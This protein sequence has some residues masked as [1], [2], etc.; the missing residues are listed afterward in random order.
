MFDKLSDI[1]VAAC[2]LDEIKIWL[3]LLYDEYLSAGNLSDERFGDLEVAFSG[4]MR[5]TEIARLR[6]TVAIKSSYTEWQ[7]IKQ[8]IETG[9]KE[10]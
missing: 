5:L 6:L 4:L 9:G 10:Q 7:N 8:R 2:G 3:K 1:E